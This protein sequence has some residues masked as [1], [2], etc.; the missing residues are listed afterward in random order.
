MK[1]IPFLESK[2][3]VSPLAGNKVVSTSP[4]VGNHA[5]NLSILV[6][7]HT[8]RTGRTTAIDFSGAQ[9]RE[10]IVGGIDAEVE[11]FVVVVDVRVVVNVVA[12]LLEAVAFICSGGDGG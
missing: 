12:G 9:D 5:R 7:N 3:K 6:E 2:L 11:A 1:S 4:R 10:L 8:V